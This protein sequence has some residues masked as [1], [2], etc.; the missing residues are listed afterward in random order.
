M[1]IFLKGRKG[2]PSHLQYALFGNKEGFCLFF[3]TAAYFHVSVSKYSEEKHRSSSFLHWCY[4]KMTFPGL[5][6][7]Y[8]HTQAYKNKP[9]KPYSINWSPF[10]MSCCLVLLSSDTLDM[11][12]WTS[13]FWICH[14]SKKKKGKCLLIYSSLHLD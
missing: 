9:T 4:I 1:L 14:S 11:L 3:K 2:I 10:L 13:T 6:I 12:S 8:T 5:L 7:S